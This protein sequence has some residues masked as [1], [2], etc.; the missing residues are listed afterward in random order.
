MVPARPALV[1]LIAVLTRRPAPLAR[2]TLSPLVA[3]RLAL[4]VHLGLPASL[5][6]LNALALARLVNT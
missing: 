2:P 3:P 1:E 5:A 4:L 6:L